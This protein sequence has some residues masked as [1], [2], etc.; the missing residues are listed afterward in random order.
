MDKKVLATFETNCVYYVLDQGLDFQYLKKLLESS[1]IEIAV[2][3]T[4]AS[5]MNV[6]KEMNRNFHIFEERIHSNSL[7]DNVKMIDSIG[8][9]GFSFWGHFIFGGEEE[10]KLFEEIRKI[11]FPKLVFPPQLEHVKDKKSY[12]RH[13]SNKVNDIRILWAHIYHKRDVF[14][15]RDANFLKSKKKKLE[16]LGAKHIMTPYEAYKTYI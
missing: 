8:I 10:Q 14:I 13:W 5:E 6:N 15:T 7:L 1:R 12:I 3:S 4:T 2:V 9:W 11:L 16:Q